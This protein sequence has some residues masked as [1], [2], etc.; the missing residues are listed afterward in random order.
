MS[1]MDVPL[2]LKIELQEIS[3]QKNAADRQRLGA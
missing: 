3:S 1:L 2:G